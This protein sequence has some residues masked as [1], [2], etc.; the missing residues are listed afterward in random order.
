MKRTVIDKNPTSDPKGVEKVGSKGGGFSF[1]QNAF[2]VLVAITVLCSN[3]PWGKT[4]KG[5]SIYVN[6]HAEHTCENIVSRFDNE[7]KHQQM[8]ICAVFDITNYIDHSFVQSYR[9]KVKAHYTLTG[10]WFST[11]THGQTRFANEVQTKTLMEYLLPAGTLLVSIGSLLTLLA[12][13]FL[14]PFKIYLYGSDAMVVGALLVV[15]ALVMGTPD[16]LSSEGIAMFVT[17]LVARLCDTVLKGLKTS[18]FSYAQL[19]LYSF[20]LSIILWQH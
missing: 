17:V 3:M 14:S 12:N 16:G 20:V 5:V 11:E 15:I 2:T 6:Q 18:F 4:S 9:E 13:L 10:S 1:L 19:V 7:L 8:N